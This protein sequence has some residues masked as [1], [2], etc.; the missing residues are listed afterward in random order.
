MGKYRF[1]P[2]AP[3]ENIVSGACRPGY[4]SDSPTSKMVDKWIEFMRERGR[5]SAFVVHLM[6]KVEHYD[7]LLNPIVGSDRKTRLV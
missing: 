6:K 2:A 7:K 3:D 1:G 5:L 4:P